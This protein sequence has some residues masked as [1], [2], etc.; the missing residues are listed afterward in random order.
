MP[1]V[2]VL[3]SGSVAVGVNAYCA[4]TGADVAGVPLIVGGVF[5]GAPLAPNLT[6]EN[7]AVAS[8]PSTPLATAR[9]AYTFA[10]IAIVTLAPC[11]RQFWPSAETY[12]VN[13]LPTRRTRT[14]YGARVTPSAI[15]PGPAHA[16]GDTR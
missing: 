12:P 14:Q 1:Y 8:D 2:S 10:P 3:P 16:P 6:L 5:A 15:P 9:P 7:A 13:T 11:C 4:P